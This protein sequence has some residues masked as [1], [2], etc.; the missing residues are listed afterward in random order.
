MEKVRT[1]QVKNVGEV[2]T[3]FIYRGYYCIKG[4]KCAYHTPNRLRSGSYLDNA[5]TDDVFTMD[6]TRFDTAEYFKQVVD[7][8]IEYVIRAHG[9]LENLFRLNS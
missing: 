8:H 9:S 1:I 6:R 5:R 7:E 4:G 2:K 3:A